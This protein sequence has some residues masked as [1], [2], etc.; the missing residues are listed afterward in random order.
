MGNVNG[1]AYTEVLTILKELNLLNSIPKELVYNMERERDLEWQFEFDKNEALENQR[2]LRK[3]AVIL[4]TLYI[5]YMCD[6]N[7]EKSYLKALYE[8][9]ENEKNTN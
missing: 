9:N 6:D 3:T 8:A 4:S 5:M 1:K 2:M 7:D